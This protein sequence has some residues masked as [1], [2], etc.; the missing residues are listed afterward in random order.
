M[1]AIVPEAT[2]LG[3]MQYGSVKWN[4]TTLLVARSAATGEDGF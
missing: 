3:F 1:A 2:E 4:G